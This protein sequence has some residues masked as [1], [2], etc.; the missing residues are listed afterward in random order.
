MAYLHLDSATSL[1]GAPS[2]R[3]VLLSELL[4]SGS[5][6][7][8]SAPPDLRERESGTCWGEAAALNIFHPDPPSH[9]PCCSIFTSPPL[10]PSAIYVER[11]T[12]GWFAYDHHHYWDNDPRPRSSPITCPHYAGISHVGIQHY[13]RLTYEYW[14]DG[15]LIGERTP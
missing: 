14:S 8:E 5:L 3:S 6:G 10:D 13:P 7:S 9:C 1:F 12:L 4:E 11:C 15:L 2:R